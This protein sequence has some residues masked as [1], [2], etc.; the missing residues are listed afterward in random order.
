MKIPIL[1]AGAGVMGSGEERAEIL[2]S[3]KLSGDFLPDH[4]LHNKVGPP[5]TSA[6]FSL[7]ECHPS[8]LLFALSILPG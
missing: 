7:K 5:G 6:N 8:F 1:P 4:T 3:N 2:I